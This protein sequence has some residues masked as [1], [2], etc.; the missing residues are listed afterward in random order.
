MAKKNTKPIP[1]RKGDEPP[2]LSPADD[3]LLDEIWEQLRK[4]KGQEKPT[5]NG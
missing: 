3:K 2:I 5:T 1:P 4:K